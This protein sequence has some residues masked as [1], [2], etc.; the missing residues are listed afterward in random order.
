[1]PDRPRTPAS[2]R[3]D[4]H[5]PARPRRSPGARPDPAPGPRARQA[6]GRACV[7]AGD[8]VGGAPGPPRRRRAAGDRDR[9]AGERRARRPG[10]EPRDAARAAAQARTTRDRPRARGRARTRRRGRRRG[11]GARRQARGDRCGRGVDRARLPD[12]IGRGGA[13]GLHQHPPGARLRRSG[14][15]RGARRRAGL[16]PGGDAA[17]A[18]RERGVRVREPDRAAPHRQRARGV[19]RRPALS[20]PRGRRPP[21]GARVLL[22]R[23]RATGEEPRGVGRRDPSRHADPGG[24]LPRRLRPR[25]RRRAPGRRL[26][27]RG[28]SRSR[29]RCDRGNVG[30]RARARGDR[31][32]AREP[33]RAVR[34]LEERGVAVHGRL[35][36][37]RSRAAPRR[38]R[39]VR[40]GRRP[41]VPIDRPR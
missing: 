23:L 35:R 4:G 17:P 15:G 27:T 16:R 40:G 14:G 26:G 30:I 12:R 39:P 28:D 29:S 18:A 38:R 31:G 3:Y 13:A 21:R 36:R 22:Q 37:A 1:M 9:T 10:D 34:H 8:R 6:G 25:S 32:I 41:L 20:R 2:T 19:R 5:R 7:G 24:R 33:R 11:R